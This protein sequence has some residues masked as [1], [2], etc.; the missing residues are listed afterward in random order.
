ML[1]DGCARKTRHYA[2]PVNGNCAAVNGRQKAPSLNAHPVKPSEIGAV[3]TPRIVVQR[4]AQIIDRSREGYRY[5]AGP[6]T[7]PKASSK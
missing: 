7:T 4:C 1:V 2:R 5:L 3:V 6:E